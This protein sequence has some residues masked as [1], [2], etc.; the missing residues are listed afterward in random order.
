MITTVPGMIVWL[1]RIA[2]AP[3]SVNMARRAIPRLLLSASLAAVVAGFAGRAEAADTYLDCD[4]EETP[5]KGAKSSYR[6]SIKFRL[7]VDTRKAQDNW[8]NEYH[9][10][11]VDSGVELLSE[12]G[13]NIKLVYQFSI[14]L[15]GGVLSGFVR[16]RGES[17]PILRASGT[18]ARAASPKS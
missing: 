1:E 3:R 5:T 2:V 16:Y 7:I 18:C 14:D 15:A 12:P 17:D 8:G 13:N 10:R 4:L 11:P 9:L 6:E